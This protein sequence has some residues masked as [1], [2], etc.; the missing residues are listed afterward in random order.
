MAEEDDI[1]AKLQKQIDLMFFVWNTVKHSKVRC[2]KGGSEQVIIVE[3]LEGLRWKHLLRVGR[4][5]PRV[6][7]FF[8]I[9]ISSAP[10]ASVNI[11]SIL[12]REDESP[13]APRVLRSDCTSMSKQLPGRAG[14]GRISSFTRFLLQN[15]CSPLPSDSDSA[16]WFKSH[17]LS[18]WFPEELQPPQL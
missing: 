3:L 18:F 6:I 10:D 1:R 2:M 5:L 4:K 12:W 8:W 7:L 9:N 17:F 13:T 16:V 14:P 15:L 11:S